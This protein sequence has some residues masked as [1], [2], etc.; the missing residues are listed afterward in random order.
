MKIAILTKLPNYYTETRLVEEASKRGHEV[1]LIRYP[2]CYVAITDHGGKVLHNGEEVKDVDAII[3]R[4]F[5]G[6]M[7][8]G[9][10]ILRQ[11]ERDSI[12][13]TAKSLALTRSAD[14]L[15]SI[16]IMSRKGI[17]VPNSVFLR[18]PSQAD[19]LIDY[20]GLPAVVRV[21]SITARHGNSTVLAETKKAVGAVIRAFYVSDSTFILQEYIHSEN[22]ASVR[23]YV[24]GSQ[25]VASAKRA[26]AGPADQVSSTED[27]LVGIAI[28]SDMQKKV[29]VKAAKSLGLACCSVDMII[30]KERSVVVG[31]DPFVGIENLEK[32]T[33][34]NIAVKLIE[35]IERN[36]KRNPKKDRVGA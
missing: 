13:S 17:D 35:Y 20:V 31:V 7:N 28:L 26:S 12:F 23:A 21:P 30:S 6:S 29:A 2:S 1:Q 3:P 34:R 32:V 24:I 27:G 18:E 33:G 11:L 5:A 16:Q 19:E 10:A 8:Y 9:V 4:S 25:V 14:M 36:A 22:T 15:R